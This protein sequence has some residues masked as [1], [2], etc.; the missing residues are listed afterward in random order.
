[1]ESALDVD[2]ARLVDLC[3][4][5]QVVELSLFGSQARGEARPDSDV[6]LLVTFEDGAPWSSWDVIAFRDELS[7]LFGRPVDL[8][9]E[10]ALRN[11]YR[12]TAIL[13]DK[14]VIYAG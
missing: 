10:R 4:R 13:R 14:R 2:R 7:A 9:E 5:W 3:R 1:M 8:I 11:P 6:D 12:K